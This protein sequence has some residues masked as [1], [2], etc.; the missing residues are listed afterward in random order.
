MVDG[1]QN[2]EKNAKEAFYKLRHFQKKFEDTFNGFESYN[3]VGA[4]L[5]LLNG[6]DRIPFLI[7]FFE[8]NNEC[9][10]NDYYKYVFLH[11]QHS[12]IC[13]II[14]DGTVSQN[15]NSI[16]EAVLGE[17]SDDLLYSGN[18]KEHAFAQLL[19]RNIEEDTSLERK[20]NFAIWNERSLEH[21]Y[22]KS[23]F[24]RLEKDSRGETLLIRGDGEVYTQSTDENGRIIYRAVNSKNK[25]K[26]FDIYDKSVINEADFK[27]DGN[28]HCIGNLVLL[29]KKENS[30]FGKKSFE[31]KRQY[32]FD[33]SCGRMK[34]S[35]RSR[36]LLH[37]LSVFAA[38]KWGVEQIQQNKK[39]FL[40]EVKKFYGIH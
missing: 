37:T 39:E 31:E 17:I 26:V 33:I 25:E 8:E 40:D 7:W 14:D 6:Q 30:T 1:V 15:A 10:L 19:R 11:L 24:Y 9:K 27:G 32:L 20:F 28:E 23:K 4:I 22:V 3:K 5:T 29:Y 21:I 16:V 36:H 2:K 13:Q 38:P 35:F 12:Q 18:N 34:E